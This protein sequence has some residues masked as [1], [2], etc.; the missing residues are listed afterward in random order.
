[1]V[2]PP[3]QQ[4]NSDEYKETTST[5]RMNDAAKISPQ[6]ENTQYNPN[7]S[8]T[9][10]APY[11]GIEN[12]LEVQPKNCKFRRGGYCITHQVQ[13]TKYWRPDKT[14]IRGKDGIFKYKY[15]RK[16]AYKCVEKTTK[17]ITNHSPKVRLVSPNRDDAVAEFG[18]SNGILEL[19]SVISLEPTGRGLERTE[20]EMESFFSPD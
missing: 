11:T 19:S 17:P 15:S 2:T 14:R 1:M 8:S 10:P 18:K 16:V 5:P 12:K 7:L 4:D 13:G 20:I 9:T 6:E 3:P